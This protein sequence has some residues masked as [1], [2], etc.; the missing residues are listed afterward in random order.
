MRIVSET[1]KKVL[2]RKL[3]WGNR[4]KQVKKFVMIIGN[5]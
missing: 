1:D 5:T 4:E 3:F 2:V